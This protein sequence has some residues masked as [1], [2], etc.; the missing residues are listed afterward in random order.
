MNN[1]KRIVND[2]I[3]DFLGC[4][5][6]KKNDAVKMIEKSMFYKLLKE[7]PDYIYKYDSEYWTEN[8][9]IENN[10]QFTDGQEC[11]NAMRSIRFLFQKYRKDDDEIEEYEE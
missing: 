7:N 5:N 3:D 8:I 2:I 4:Y 6:I 9:I 11:A 10:I 1:N